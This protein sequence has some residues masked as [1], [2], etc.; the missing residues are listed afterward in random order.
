M[1][2]Q[3]GKNGLNSSFFNQYAGFHSSLE[4]IIIHSDLKVYVYE[5]T[6]QCTNSVQC[7]VTQKVEAACNKLWPFSLASKFT[8]SYSSL[9]FKVLDQ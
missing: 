6:D 3:P 2:T 1:Y 4:T 9:L 5:Q 8:R 7:L